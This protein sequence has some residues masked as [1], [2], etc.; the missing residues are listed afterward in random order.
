MVQMRDEGQIIIIV[1]F[2]MTFAIISVVI[3]VNEISAIQLTIEHDRFD[4]YY[5]AVR[6]I[7][8]EEIKKAMDENDLNYLNSYLQS[9]EDELRSVGLKNGYWLTLYLK[10]VEVVDGNIISVTLELKMRDELHEYSEE[11]IILR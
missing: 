7:V 4:G 8:Y 11:L 5:R 10:N 6:M 2:L 1:A 9:L 3:T